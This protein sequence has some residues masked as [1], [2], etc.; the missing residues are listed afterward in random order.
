MDIEMPTS[1]EHVNKLWPAQATTISKFQCLKIDIR[2]KVSHPYRST[3]KISV[4]Y[5]YIPILT[6]LENRQEDKNLWTEW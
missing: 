2:D 4:L 3:R 5:S 1:S 6:F